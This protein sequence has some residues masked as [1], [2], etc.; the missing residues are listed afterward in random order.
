M[1]FQIHQPYRLR[2][3]TVFDLGRSSVYE[4]D[5]RNCDG[6][7]H[8]AR[9]CYLPMN[10]VLLRCIRRHGKRFRVAFSLSGTALDQFEQYAPE[11]VDSF[12]A[13]A[14]TG[15]VEF[16]AETYGHSLAFL[17]SREEFRRQVDMHRAR[18]ETLFGQTPRVFRHTE[19]IYNNDLAGEI[20]DMGF[21]AVLAEGT[22]QVLGWRSPNFVYQPVNCARLKLLLKHCRLSEDIARRFSRRDWDQWPLTAEKFA[23]WC[24]SVN[25]AGE[26]VNLFMDYETFGLRH[27]KESGIFHFMEALP[28]ALLA[29]KDFYFRTPREAATA[30]SA[31]GRIDV[32]QYISWAGPDHDLNLWLGND[33]QKDAI[34]S[35]YA[36][37]DS[38]RQTGSEDLSRAWTRLQTADHFSHMST[39][40]FN[41]PSDA[42]RRENPYGSP[43][44]A[45]INY[46]N[47]LADYELLLNA[48]P[49]TTP[50]AAAGRK[51]ASGTAKDARPAKAKAATTKKTAP[52]AP[53]AP[54]DE[55]P[56]PPAR[57]TRTRPAK[58]DKP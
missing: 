34:H 36:L 23:A 45:Y 24:H 7:L 16:L 20:E 31:M 37:K 22:D 47:V 55:T 4:D 44:D 18:I 35:L 40:W 19:L 38:V 1:Y 54:K 46:M 42:R 2:R 49:R 13:L 9:L 12:K 26:V 50:D 27:K 48:E 28:A 11:V 53:A 30:H 39:K 58:K 3:Y 8:A 21:A 33:M 56:T 52:K 51:T 17:Y 5:D 15:C 43:Y 57:S 14:A 41:A 29:H 10:D 32:P 25:G 6:L